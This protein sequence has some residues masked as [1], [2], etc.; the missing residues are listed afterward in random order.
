[1]SA[2]ADVEAA[3]DIDTGFCEHFDFFDEGDGINH[4][5][6]A[7]NGVLFRTKNAA[8]NELE[9]VLVLADD[10]GVAGV[11]ATG[12][13]NDV[14]E[15][16]GEIVHDFAFTFVTPLRANDDDRFHSLCPF[17]HYKITNP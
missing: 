4:D 7:D 8:R 16:A 14:V 12:N 5:A 2:I 3:A 17:Q 11:V 13:A 15:R 10:D 6:H 9:N 1:M